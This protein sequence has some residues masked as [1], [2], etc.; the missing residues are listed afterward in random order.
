ML[1]AALHAGAT[2][3][4]GPVACFRKC[5][6]EGGGVGEVSL[7]QSAKAGADVMG[8]QVEESRAR[9]GKGRC[10]ARA[11]NALGNWWNGVH[12]NH[13]IHVDV[14]CKVFNQTSIQTHS[15]PRRR[16]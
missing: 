9:G 8:R 13:E 3:R 14:S 4:N 15:N 1:R 16:P 12:V 5:R 2:T 6:P 7:N 10:Q 11:S